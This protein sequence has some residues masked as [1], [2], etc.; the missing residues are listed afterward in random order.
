VSGIVDE[1]LLDVEQAAGPVLPDLIASLHAAP[2]SS[3][4]SPFAGLGAGSIGS[5]SNASSPLLQVVVQQE[6]EQL[7]T[8]PAGAAA[9]P[10]LDVSSGGSMARMHRWSSSSSGLADTNVPVLS[11]AGAGSISIS[12]GSPGEGLP[13]FSSSPSS[14]SP[15]SGAMMMA[16][17]AAAAAAPSPTGHVATKVWRQAGSLWV[18]MR[19]KVQQRLSSSGSNGSAPLAAGLRLLVSDTASFDAAATTPGG[20]AAAGTT[21]DQ[22]RPA[23][24][25]ASSAA[26]TVLAALDEAWLGGLV[27]QPHNRTL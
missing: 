21:R 25:A 6:V 5:G 12:I 20:S 7:Q 19:T 10:L 26:H 3:A 2:A 11:S 16:A 18:S 15:S 27:V 13:G 9:V 8:E 4:A 23:A 24:P 17:A 22:Q 1:L 14:N